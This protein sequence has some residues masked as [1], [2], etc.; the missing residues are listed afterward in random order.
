MIKQLIKK[1][2]YRE[3]I[4]VMMCQKFENDLRQMQRKEWFK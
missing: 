1:L 3:Y 4:P 2:T